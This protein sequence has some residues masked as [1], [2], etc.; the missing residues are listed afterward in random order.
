MSA[1]GQGDFSIPR[2]AVCA[3]DQILQHSPGPVRG[4]GAD[5][6]GVACG[7]RRST[8]GSRASQYKRA[9]GGSCWETKDTIRAK[10][11]E[12]ATVLK[13]SQE[14][15]STRRRSMSRLSTPPPLRS[16]G[17]GGDIDRF[18][19]QYDVAFANPLRGAGT[20]YSESAMQ[21]GDEIRCR[22]RHCSSALVTV[23][24]PSRPIL[25]SRV[26]AGCCRGTS[27][28]GQPAASACTA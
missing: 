28:K 27:Q 5:D 6:I 10:R 9:R 20:V 2:A 11:T 26:W 15:S 14:W 23:A 12:A 19:T 21:E 13:G 17:E 4:S 22:T 1:R 18:T 8:T 3:R 24:Q 7:A 16:W 25:E